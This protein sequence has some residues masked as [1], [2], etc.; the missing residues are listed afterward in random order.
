MLPRMAIALSL[1]LVPSAAW[2]DDDRGVSVGGSV[3]ATNMESRT[4]LSL[5]G[6]FGFRFTRVV[7]LEI[8]STVVPRLRSPFPGALI[9]SWVATTV[10]TISSGSA[11]IP[12]IYPGPVFSDVGGRAVIFSNNVRI[13]MPVTTTRATPYFVAGGGIAN[14]R[15]TATF[16]YPFPI[17]LSLPPTPSPGPVPAPVPQYRNISQPVESSIT[18]LA[19]TLGGGVDIHVASH[20]SVGVDLRL[21][22]LLGQQDQNAGRFGVGVRYTF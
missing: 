11:A 6:T 16:T 17:P 7:S 12:Q 3:S 2:A 1:L 21:I 9:Q 14:L 19:L 22:R 20:L 18:E 10:S 4:E 15:R 8:E 13:D 5:A